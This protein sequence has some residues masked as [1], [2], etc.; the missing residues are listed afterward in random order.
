MRVAFSVDGKPVSTN[1]SYLRSANRRMRKSPEAIAWQ[2]RIQYAARRAAKG[3][4]KL[5]GDIE[6]S[7]LIAFP[8]RRNDIDGPIKGILDAMQGTIYA[9]DRQVRR[10]VVEC[11][12]LTEGTGVE[13]RAAP[14]VDIAVSEMEST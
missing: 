10:L 9:N 12:A 2:T 13:G 11:Y 7:L 3:V 6:V 5:A 4:R 8:T 14:G 1:A